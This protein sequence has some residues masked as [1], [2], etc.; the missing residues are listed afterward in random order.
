MK[1]CEHYLAGRK[2]ITGH[3]HASTHFPVIALKGGEKG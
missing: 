2:S 1:G 3:R